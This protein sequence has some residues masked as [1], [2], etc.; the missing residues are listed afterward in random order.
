MRARCFC[1]VR[2]TGDALFS[3]SLHPTPPRRRSGTDHGDC[4]RTS[5]SGRRL[6]GDKRLELCERELLELC[7][8]HGELLIVRHSLLGEGEFEGLG[9]E[10]RIKN[11]EL[12]ILLVEVFRS[13]KG[14]LGSAEAIATVTCSAVA[15]V[16][17]FPCIENGVSAAITVAIGTAGGVGGGGVPCS[18]VAF[19]SGINGAISARF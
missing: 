1:D 13:N 4:R 15:I 18:L 9:L 8:Q 6:H 12:R 3:L 2:D 10:L 11:G 14:L 5:L 19:L 17:L 16:T 7:V